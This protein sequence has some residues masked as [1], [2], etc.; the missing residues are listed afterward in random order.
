[1]TRMP[2]VF[3]NLLNKIAKY[4]EQGGCFWLTA[5]DGEEAVAAAAVFRSRVILLSDSEASNRTKSIGDLTSPAVDNGEKK[6]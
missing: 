3:L 5:Y 4:S 1:M 6:H 2:Q